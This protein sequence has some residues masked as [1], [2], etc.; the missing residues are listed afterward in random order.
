[1]NEPR[2]WMFK[3]WINVFYPHLANG[4]DPCY[5]KMRDAWMAA[6]RLARKPMPC[7]HPAAC[8]TGGDEVTGYCGW[9]AEIS[10]WAGKLAGATAQIAKLKAE[11]AGS[12]KA[13]K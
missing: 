3:E 2:E 8:V 13:A 1:M 9:C 10:E 4:G 11:Q 12:R 6:D 5:P 7:G